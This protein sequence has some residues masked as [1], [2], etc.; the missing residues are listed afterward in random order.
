MAA[1]VAKVTMQ[2]SATGP[3][4][5]P[6][7]REP[8]IKCRERG[9]TL[10]EIMVVLVI[11]AVMAGLLVFS[12]KDS[13]Q[14][15]VHREATTLA[16]LINAASDEA[17]MRGIELGLVIDDAGYQFV[18]FDPEKKQWQ[19]ARERALL[20]HTFTEPYTIEFSID[21][22]Q[23][24]EPTRQ[25]IQA[26]AERTEDVALRPTLLIFSSG[27]TT[28]FR[29]ALSAGQEPPINLIGDGLNPVVIATDS[30][31]AQLGNQG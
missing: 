25:R 2:M 29:L 23:V 12:F 19:P 18:Y 8:L 16:A 31:A 10:I 1:K 4:T 14:Q 13:P 7:S 15:R 3:R 6:L 22:A 9:F 24:D 27:E 26:L 17:V 30:D 5:K 20:R 28:P 11:V 21:G